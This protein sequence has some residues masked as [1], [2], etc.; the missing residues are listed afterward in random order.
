MNQIPNVQPDLLEQF[1]Q[2]TINPASQK[3]GEKKRKDQFKKLIAG[4]VGVR[5]TPPTKGSHFLYI[6]YWLTSRLHWFLLRIWK[7]PFC[8]SRRVWRLLKN[9]RLSCVM[10]RVLAKRP[11]MESN[12]FPLSSL[13]IQS[14]F[15]NIFHFFLFIYSFL[16]LTFESGFLISRNDQD[17]DFPSLP[18][19]LPAYWCSTLF[20]STETSWSAV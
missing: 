10:K 7:W 3:V 12:L 11:V 18:P 1:D 2:K 19:L 4:A 5:H 17:S 20:L 16:P 14:H 15:C 9:D 8:F 13:S 6:L